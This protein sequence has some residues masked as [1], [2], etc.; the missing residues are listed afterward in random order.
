MERIAQLYKDLTGR[1]PQ[2]IAPLAGAGSN[3]Q[4]FRVEGEGESLIAV[5]GTNQE[6]NEAFI[7]LAKR[8]K[9]E[10][11]ANIKEFFGDGAVPYRG[12][13][14]STPTTVSAADKA[15]QAREDAKRVREG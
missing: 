10:Y 3:R 6:E 12:A 5:I 13:R 8:F 4:Y 7:D 2:R 1:E 15:K 14:I 9:E 11:D